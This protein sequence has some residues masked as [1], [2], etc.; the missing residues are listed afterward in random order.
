MEDATNMATFIA[1]RQELVRTTV[2]ESVSKLT[3]RRAHPTVEFTE[4]R[5]PASGHYG[6]GANVI[7]IRIPGFLDDPGTSDGAI[8]ATVA[9]EC[10]HWADPMLD[11]H[12]RLVLLCVVP[13]FLLF[14]AAMP[15]IIISPLLG[16]RPEIG[17][18]IVVFSI[19]AGAILFAIA[20]RISHRGEYEADR[21]AANLVGKT[22]VIEM[23]RT[24]P[25][26]HRATD[27]HP[28]PKARIRRLS[29]ANA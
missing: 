25:H 11:V 26:Q 15:V 24:F 14:L 21:M 6:H 18:P 23:L 4:A 20:V 29:E 17:G 9:H 7:T 1:E 3:G 28:S 22:A 12:R 2:R 16:W 10:S 8:Q 19:L 13:A 27:T 5:K